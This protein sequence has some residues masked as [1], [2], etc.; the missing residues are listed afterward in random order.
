[1]TGLDILHWALNALGVPA[2][3]LLWNMGNRLT[4]LE[5]Q[6]EFLIKKAGGGK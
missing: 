1:M 6:I 5:T 3:G 2:V 4:K